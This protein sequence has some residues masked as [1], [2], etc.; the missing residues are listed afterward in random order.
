VNAICNSTAGGGAG[1]GKLVV[2]VLGS[3]GLPISGYSFADSIVFDGDDARAV[4]TW[5]SSP[6]RSMDAF[7]HKLVV[8][9]VALTGSAQL[10]AIRGN[11]TRGA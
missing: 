6:A 4:I 10:F 11:F 2:Q 8:L 7:A 1:N 3:D 5:G 9:E